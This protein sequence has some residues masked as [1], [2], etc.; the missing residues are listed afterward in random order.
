MRL[1]VKQ[2]TRIAVEKVRGKPEYFTLLP[3]EHIELNFNTGEFE[4]FNKFTGNTIIKYGSSSKS[5]ISRE[6]L[7]KIKNKIG[8]DFLEV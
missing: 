7:H 3:H 2:G 5:K 4:V 6:F 8:D 1:K